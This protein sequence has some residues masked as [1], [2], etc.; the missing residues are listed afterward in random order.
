[1]SVNGNASHEIDVRIVQTVRALKELNPKDQRQED[2]S[3]NSD[4][5]SGDSSHSNEDKN[6]KSKITDR[7]SHTNLKHIHLNHSID[8]RNSVKENT[9]KIILN[10]KGN[11]LISTNSSLANKKILIESRYKNT[12]SSSSGSTHKS[13]ANF[14]KNL[15]N[16]TSMKKYKATCV[17]I[18]KDD[19]EIKSLCEI[20]GVAYTNYSFDSILEKNIF[21]SQVFLYKLEML[22]A[23]DQVLNKNYKDKFFRQEIYTN[24]YL[25]SIDIKY[26]AQME[27]LNERFDDCAE[28]IANIDF[29]KD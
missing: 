4:K 8:K 9:E 21:T 22:L 16:E 14:L 27:S 24:L 6:E 23:S 25:R 15:M 17:A 7:F 3:D 1:M 11:S 19:K 29:S 26:K 5:T 12:P 13:R 2:N 20:C 28:L 10:Q 18:L